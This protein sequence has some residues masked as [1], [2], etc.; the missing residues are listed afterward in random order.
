MTDGTNTKPSASWRWDQTSP[1]NWSGWR[2]FLNGSPW[3]RDLE[4]VPHHQ[5][6]HPGT[7]ATVG[8]ACVTRLY[9]PLSSNHPCVVVVARK[10]H[11]GQR[12]PGSECCLRSATCP[13][14]VKETA[15][16]GTSNRA[17]RGISAWIESVRPPDLSTTPFPFFIG[18]PFSISSPR[19]QT[20]PISAQTGAVTCLCDGTPARKAGALA[21]L[22]DQRTRW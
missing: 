21:V 16:C 17:Q 2:Q 13:P 18:Q 6:L 9:T 19:I 20:P 3:L 8:V 10:A 11:Q 7:A 12:N 4:V 5:R 1:S 14:P 15:A 22:N